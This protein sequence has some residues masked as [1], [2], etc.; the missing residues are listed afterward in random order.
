VVPIQ[1]LAI[2]FRSFGVRFL[3]SLDYWPDV[4]AFNMVSGKCVNNKTHFA[5]P[6]DFG[7]VSFAVGIVNIA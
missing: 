4:S 6:L 1:D 5:S 2:D 3:S 7:I